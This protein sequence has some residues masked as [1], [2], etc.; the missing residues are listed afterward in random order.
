MEQQIMKHITQTDS[1]RQSDALF[2]ARLEAEE[3]RRFVKRLMA[4][5]TVFLLVWLAG[6]LYFKQPPLFQWWQSTARIQSVTP[7]AAGTG[8]GTVEV[9]QLSQELTRLQQQ[10]GKAVTETLSMKLAALEDRIQ[11][12]RAGLQE[13]EL[14]QS[15]KEDIGLLA[16][17]AHQRP[18]LVGRQSMVAVTPSSQP[19]AV[20][21]PEVA[22]L[23][24]FSRLETL[25]YLS[26][27]T[28]ALIIIVA[29]GYFFR[30]GIQLK[31]LGTDLSRLHGQLPSQRRST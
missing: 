28:F 22:L 8:V 29:A 7:K 16:G 21:V 30:C 25:V 15:I 27:G 3:Q 10:L 9:E 18:S 26:L 23:E 2:L 6:L 4:G 1:A 31:R 20:P 24:R 17:R 14:I 11:M 5:L 19:E 12:G 13:L